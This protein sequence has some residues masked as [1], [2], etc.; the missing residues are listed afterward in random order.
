MKTDSISTKLNNLK[1]EEGRNNKAYEGEDSTTPFDAI[2]SFNHKES[3][4]GQVQEAQGIEVRGS[5]PI[6]F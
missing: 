2:F 1:K 3:A 6:T 4:E 5:N